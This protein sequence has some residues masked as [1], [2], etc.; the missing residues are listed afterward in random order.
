MPKADSPVSMPTAELGLHVKSLTHASSEA[1]QALHDAKSRYIAR[2]PHSKRLFD[3]ACHALP[4]GNTRTLLYTSPFP[5]YLAR[6][7]GY[8]VFTEDGHA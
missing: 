7:E 6:G 3:E 5:T 4:G 2:N 8:Q 1:Q